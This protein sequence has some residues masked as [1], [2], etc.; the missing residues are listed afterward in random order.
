MYRNVFVSERET[1]LLLYEDTDY[2]APCFLVIS[3]SIWF[4]DNL[5]LYRVC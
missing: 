5:A 2:R 1:R 3:T 4:F